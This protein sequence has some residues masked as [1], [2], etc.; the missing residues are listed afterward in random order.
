M[1]RA[2][3][4]EPVDLAIA[5]AAG[6]V[7][8]ASHLPGFI[9]ASPEV[10]ARE[11]DAIFMRD[12]LC[13]ARAEEIAEPGDYLTLRI[14]DEPIVIARGADGGVRAFA[15]VCA[16]RGVEVAH[17]RGRARHFSCPYHGCTYDLDGRLTGAAFMNDAVGFDLEACRLP[18]LRAGLWRGWVFVTF[19]AAAEP[20]ADFVADFERDFGLLDMERCRLAFRT[21]IEI[22]C[23]WKFVVENLSDIYHSEVL[24][25]KTFGGHIKTEEIR[26]ELKR[27]GGNTGFYEAAPHNPDAHPYFGKM[28]WLADRTERFARS[29]FLAPNFDMFARIDEVHPVVVWPLSPSRSLIVLYQLFPATAFDHPDFAAKAPVYRDYM[30]RIVEEDRTMIESLQRAMSAR[31]YRPGRLSYLERAIHNAIG[32][33]IERVFRDRPGS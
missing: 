33:Y 29:G 19:D 23:N 32:Y 17:G 31:H 22:E 26:Y 30:V 15:N 25:K 14:T 7:T 6:P 5:A 1:S 16:H 27:R 24:H 9:Y 8:R 11:K 10:Y 12:W 4:Q 21:A 2:W 20:L 13:V 28:P 3:H 18:P